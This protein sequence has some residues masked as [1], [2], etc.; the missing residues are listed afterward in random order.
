M[1]P[2]PSSDG[3]VISLWWH[4]AR[5]KAKPDLPCPGFSAALPCPVGAPQSLE[6]HKSLAVLAQLQFPSSGELF[7]SQMKQSSW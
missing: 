1:H 3:W 4:Q 2:D 5:S 7:R 6:A